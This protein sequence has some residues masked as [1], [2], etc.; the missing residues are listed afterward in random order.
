MERLDPL[1]QYG[2]DYYKK[3]KERILSRKRNRYRD[4]PEVRRKRIESSKN[5]Y[6][7]NRDKILARLKSQYVPAR[8]RQQK[9]LA[10]NPI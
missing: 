3:N 1:S 7:R 4:N 8:I 9:Y 10:E 6:R 2:K 5:Y